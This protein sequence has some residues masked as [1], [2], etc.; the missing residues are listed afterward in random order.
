MI[1]KGDR[2]KRVVKIVTLVIILFIPGLLHFYLR[3]TGEN[4]YVNL[5]FLGSTGENAVKEHELF[6]AADEA[7]M[8]PENGFISVVNFV[9]KDCDA[10]GV[11][12]NQAM[13]KVAGKFQGHPYVKL[14]SIGLDGENSKDVIAELARPYNVSGAKWD[15]LYG[16]TDQVSRL[17]KEDLFIDAFQDSLTHELVHSPFF[18]LLDSDR[19]IRGYYEFFA[20]DEVDRLIGEIILLT[21]E[22]ARKREI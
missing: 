22:E 19:R 8:F 20:K 12:M 2:G 6:N 4:V 9:H 11:Y 3:Q 17:A 15:F 16:S 10:F 5:P 21:T 13:A 1:E 7:V 14:Y 18:V